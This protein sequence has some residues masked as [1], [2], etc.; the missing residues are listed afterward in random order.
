MKYRLTTLA[1]FCG[2]A[3]F[4]NGTVQK[5]ARESDLGIKSVEDNEWQQARREMSRLNPGD[6][7]KEVSHLALLRDPP[8]LKRNSERE[9]EC[10]TGYIFISFRNETA[11]AFG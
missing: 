8:K 7:H 3:S 6:K 10:Y 5:G 4:D 1:D 9:R 2:A 11:K